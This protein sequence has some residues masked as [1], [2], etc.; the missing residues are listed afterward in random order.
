MA[1][2][3]IYAP[4]A[5]RASSLEQ[6]ANSVGYIGSASYIVQFAHDTLGIAGRNEPV[7]TQRTNIYRYTNA[8]ADLNADGKQNNVP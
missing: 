4:A 3:R 2:G 5:L 8:F 7:A 1:V 6:D